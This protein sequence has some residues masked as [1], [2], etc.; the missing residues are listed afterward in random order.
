LG[1]H[2]FAQSDLCTNFAQI[3]YPKTPLNAK[4][5]LQI[6]GILCNTL[7]NETSSTGKCENSMFAGSSPAMSTHFKKGLNV[8]HLPF[9]IGRNTE[10]MQTKNQ[11]G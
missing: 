8:Q 5:I 3:Y 4:N 2:T 7:G 10:A 9:F 6:K 11:S 1:L